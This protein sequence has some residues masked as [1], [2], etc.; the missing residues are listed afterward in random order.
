MVEFTSEERLQIAQALANDMGGDSA[1]VGF[2]PGDA[3]DIFCK[4]W[5]LV[6]AVLGYLKPLLPAPVG[7]VIGALITAG[8]ILHGKIC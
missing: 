3:K 2:A 7:W 8:D 6:K 1:S 5:D 4:N